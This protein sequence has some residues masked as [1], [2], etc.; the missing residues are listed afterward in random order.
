MHGDGL[1]SEERLLQLE[2]DIQKFESDKMTLDEVKRSWGEIL[3]E[4]VKGREQSL[5]SNSTFPPS[6]AGSFIIGGKGTIS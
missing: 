4:L 1:T 2:Q 5:A 6:S 3:R